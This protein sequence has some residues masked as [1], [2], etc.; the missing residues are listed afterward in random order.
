MD[1]NPQ[2]IAQR[3]FFIIKIDIG[4]IGSQPERNGRSAEQ[5]QDYSHVGEFRK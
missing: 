1:D 5:K 2:P 4:D 3:E